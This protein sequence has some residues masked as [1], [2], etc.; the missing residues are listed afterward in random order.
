MFGR[1]FEKKNKILRTYFSNKIEKNKCYKKRVSV[2]DRIL[3]YNM[4]LKIKNFLLLSKELTCQFDL[5][6]YI[7]NKKQIK[8]YSR[9]TER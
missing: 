6:E 7:L 4:N 3:N 5:D 8:I 9:L 1:I 2:D